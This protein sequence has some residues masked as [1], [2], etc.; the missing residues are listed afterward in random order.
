MRFSALVETLGSAVQS[1]S[2]TARPE[3]DP[4]ILGPAAITDAGPQTITYLE[5]AKFTP[6]LK[7]TQAAAVILP[8]DETLQ[9]LAEERG[10]AWLSVADPRLAFAQVIALFYQPYR[11]R[12]GIHPS[13]VIDPSVQLGREVHIGAHVVIEANCV[14]GDGACIQANSVLYP[15]V[16]LG[17]RSRLHANCTIHERVQIGQDCVIHSGAVIG[18]E[19]FGFVPSPA[20]WVKMEQSG[21]V[22]LEDG[23]EVGCNSAI[24]RPAVGETRVGAGTK[25]DN[26]VHIAHGCQV[27]QACALA[28]QVGLAG[29][30]KVGN[31]VLLAGQVGAANQTEI[32]DRVIASAQSGLHGK[33]GA[34]EVVSGTPYM[35]HGDYLKSSALYPKLAE[36]FRTVRKLAK[37]KGAG[38]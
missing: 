14:V 38:S 22:V 23:V 36:L 32:G 13:A 28:A 18:A 17:D 9:A 16:V 31:Q 37:N 6:A 29:G 8:P 19:G 7:T 3:E 21:V 11:P 26:L 10:L 34:G 30:V 24:D 25:I 27:G 20:G 33:I 35:A 15:S 12:P 5:N 4:D 1:H 2:L